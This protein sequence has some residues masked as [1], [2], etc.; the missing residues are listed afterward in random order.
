MGFDKK[1]LE[2]ITTDLIGWIKT[3]LKETGGDSVVIGISGG[4]DS[5]IVAALLVEA[6]GKENVYGI[7]LPNGEQKDISM[8]YDLCKHLDIPHV[9][10]PINEISG[11]FF[12]SLNDL[13]SK[14]FLGAISDKTQI[15]LLPRVRMS[16]LFAIS[17]SIRNSRVVNNGNLSE[18]WIGYTTLYGDNTGAFAPLA[19]FTSEEVIEIGRYIGL[20]DKFVDKAPEDGLTGSTDEEVIGYTYSV[21]NKYIREGIIEDEETKEKID[22]MHRE[23]RFK[24]EPMLVYESKLP[25]KAED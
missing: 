23:S 10:V 9:E 11:E 13:S 16:M 12:N 17:Q 25:I 4:K 18:R 5:S 7:L 14:N 22:K 19:Q 3:T 2:R 20:D 21:L 24:F 6:I 1:N 15:N 8:A